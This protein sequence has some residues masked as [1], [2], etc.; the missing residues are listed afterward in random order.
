VANDFQLLPVA[1]GRRPEPAQAVAVQDYVDDVLRAGPTM[2]PDW[3]TL[4][5]L[6]CL[7]LI[8]IQFLWELSIGS[9]IICS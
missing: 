2:Q 9:Q 8:G 3:R 5:L 7:A 4:V 6:L 1:F